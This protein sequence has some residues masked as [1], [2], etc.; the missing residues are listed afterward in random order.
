DDATGLFALAGRYTRAGQ[1]LAAG[2]DDQAGQA[3][4][5]LQRVYREDCFLELTR[6]GLDGEDDFNG[7]ALHSASTRGSPVL[8]SNGVRCLDADGFEAHEARVCIASGRVLDD[9]KRP[10][11]YAPGQYLKSSEEM[12]ALFAG[13]P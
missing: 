13:V 4:A 12:A 6:C 2:R 10:K 7:F 8:A 9:P 11:D 5:D 1:L 3:L